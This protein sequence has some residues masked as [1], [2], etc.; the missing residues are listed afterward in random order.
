MCA[1]G[2]TAAQIAQALDQSWVWYE[3][4]VAPTDAQALEEFLPPFEQASR[5]IAALRERWNPKDLT[6]PT[7]PPPL[8]RAAYAPTPNPEANEALVGSPQRVA[9]H[10]ALLQAQGVRNLM[11]TNR[12]LLSPAQT[13]AALR[14]LSAEVMPQFRGEAPSS[15]PPV[16]TTSA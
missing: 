10:I 7:P 9:A 12:G 16:S 11:L 4:H 3:A 15:C 6:L 5:S 14:L 1:A 13:Q 8:P 2:F